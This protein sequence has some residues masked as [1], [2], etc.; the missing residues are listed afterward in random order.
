MQPV[1]PQARLWVLTLNLFAFFLGWRYHI[2]CFSSGT[3]HLRNL[4]FLLSTC[5]VS[6]SFEGRL[7]T[8]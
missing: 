5:T 6:G 4:L 7:L 3:L 8:V 2:L 1:E